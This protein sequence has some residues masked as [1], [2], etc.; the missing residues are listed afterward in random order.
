MSTNF[1]SVDVDVPIAVAYDE[2]TKLE[3]FPVFI[4]NVASVTETEVDQHHWV[5]KI[6]GVEREFDTRIVEKVPQQRIEWVN[7]NGVDHRGAVTFESASPERTTITVE[8][9]LSPRTMVE[10]VADE[11]GLVNVPMRS[12][13]NGFKASVEAL[14]TGV[15]H[16]APNNPST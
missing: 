14:L 16:N 3:R 4:D 8:L 12:G 2:W 7:V 6:A 1:T 15:Q 9:D 13:M 10:R 5:T 11:F